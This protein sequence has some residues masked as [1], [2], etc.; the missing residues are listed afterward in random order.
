MT[1]PRVTSHTQSLRLLVAALARSSPHGLHASVEAGP[2]S[3]KNRTV[4]GD[5]ALG[6]MSQ[7]S[8]P[9]R[10]PT[11]RRCRAVGH[12][13]TP[14]SLHT[15]KISHQQTCNHTQNSLNDAPLHEYMYHRS[16]SVYNVFQVSLYIGAF[17]NRALYFM[18]TCV[19]QCLLGIQHMQVYGCVLVMPCV[20][21]HCSFKTVGLG[22]FIR[23]RVVSFNVTSPYDG[24][25][26]A[27]CT[28]TPNSTPTYHANAEMPACAVWMRIS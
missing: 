23:H 27:T 8:T 26:Y 4:A 28:L 5:M 17:L 19:V 6:G 21:R 13:R 15:G 1:V 10:H 3:R 22:F 9:L 2:C 18:L 25:H 16:E 20:F 12:L 7:R 14:D 11:A 24:T